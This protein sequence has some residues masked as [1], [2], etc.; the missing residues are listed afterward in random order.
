MKVTFPNPVSSTSSKKHTNTEPK[1]KKKELPYDFSLSNI[2]Q[3]DREELLVLQSISSS[4][5]QEF[6]KN[7]SIFFNQMTE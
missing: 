7:T 3:E 5:S 6:Q 1:E 2:P 4:N